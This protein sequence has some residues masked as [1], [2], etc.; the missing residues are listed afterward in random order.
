MRS[1]HAKNYYDYYLA[2]FLFIPQVQFRKPSGL[3]TP[4]KSVQVVM[5]FLILETSPKSKD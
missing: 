5:I 3:L 4:I 2:L 1:N